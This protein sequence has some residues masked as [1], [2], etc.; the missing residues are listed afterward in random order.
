VGHSVEYL[1]QGADAAAFLIEG[2]GGNSG[3]DLVTAE[4]AAHGDRLDRREP[5]PHHGKQLEAG[6]AGHVEVGEKDVRHLP[7]D[8]AQ[9]GEAVFSNAGVIPDLRQY[10]GNRGSNRRLIVHDEE[11]WLCL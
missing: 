1:Q 4:R 3:R 8:L 10:M 11:F 5:A 9:R 7:A 6:H 2:V